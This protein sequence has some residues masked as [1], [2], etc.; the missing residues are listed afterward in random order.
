M[1]ER[2]R[3]SALEVWETL[4]PASQGLKWAALL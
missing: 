2:K 1:L 3:P 4:S